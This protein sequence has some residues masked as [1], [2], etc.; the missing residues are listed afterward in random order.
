MKNIEEFSPLHIFDFNGNKT[1]FDP[2]SFYL[3][4]F[5][6]ENDENNLD[7]IKALYSFSKTL[8]AFHMNSMRRRMR[9]VSTIMLNLAHTCNLR[10][11]YCF[12]KGGDYGK[13][14]TL[15][16][17]E[18]AKRAVD[19]L[20]NSNDKGA[21]CGIVYFGGEP[22]TNYS[23]LES[24]TLY[25]EDRAK[26]K[27][28]QINFQ[29]VTNGT[30]LSEKIIDFIIEHKI[31]IQISLDGPRVINDKLR[32]YSDG[33]GS[34]DCVHSKIIM[35]R[36]KGFTRLPVRSTITHLNCDINNIANFFYD[37]GF[38]DVKQVPVMFSADEFSLTDKDVEIIKNHYNKKADEIIKSIGHDKETNLDLFSPIVSQLCQGYKKNYYCGAG[39]EI[40]AVTPDGKLY[41]C[42]RLISEKGN[43]DIGDI[44]G[45]IRAIPEDLL[46]WGA[47]SVDE[48]TSCRDCWAKFFCG[49]GCSASAYYVHEDLSKN[50]ETLCEIFKAIVEN[51]IKIYYFINTMPKE[52]MT[53]EYRLGSKPVST[54]KKI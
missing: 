9:K 7:I 38:T 47:Y 50:D 28:L 4:E 26:D 52:Y 53:I 25:A 33:R 29:L 45:G 32:P 54:D 23:V 34:F 48:R 27:G 1:I 8:S 20:I 42:H 17:L 14:S 21:R 41:L 39:F 3:F 22:L 40:L 46:S 6:D 16:D 15:M 24:C 11:V 2:N 44:Y 35:L 30:L 31:S 12:A 13:R 49:G 5:K 36:Q 19:F 43:L 10:C 51:A 18:V 37:I